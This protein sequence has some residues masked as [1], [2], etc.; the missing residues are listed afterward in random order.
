[1]ERL[2]R[3][4]I[5]ILFLI[6]RTLH[7]RVNK[8][9]NKKSI[10]QNLK[11]FGSGYGGW[12]IHGKSIVSQSRI[13]SLGAGE[14]ISFDVE[15]ANSFACSVDIYDPTPRAIEHFKLVEKNLG[16]KQVGAYNNNGKQPIGAYNLEKV[17]PGQIC[18]FPKAIWTYS[19][20][21]KFFE[22]KELKNVSHSIKPLNVTTEKDRNYIL[23]ECVDILEISIEAYAILKLDIEGAEINVLERLLE[24]RI[25]KNLP[26]QILVEFDVLRA[27]S[28]ENFRNVVKID[29][30][31][32]NRGYQLVAVENF[33]FTYCKLELLVVS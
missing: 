2:L 31:L 3:V 7:L 32:K 1:M 26:S 15:I 14:D 9:K 28:V 4:K 29:K 27:G 11:R 17:F 22:P 23:V 30:K 19:G 21:I 24:N 33:N 5:A 16:Q 13:L 18:L 8:N 6:F 12:Y 20:E 10:N 25:E